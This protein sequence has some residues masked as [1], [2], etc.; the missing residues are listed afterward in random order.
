MAQELKTA[1]TTYATERFNTGQELLGPILTCAADRACICQGRNSHAAS[2]QQEAN[3]VQVQL[4]DL[5]PAT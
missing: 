1:I 3:T 5:L 4:C 2:E